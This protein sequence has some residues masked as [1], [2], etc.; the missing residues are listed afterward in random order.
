MAPS[1]DS[2]DGAAPGAGTTTTANAASTNAVSTSD[3]NE[4]QAAF[5]ES[6]MSAAK[7]DVNREATANA[8]TNA[9]TFIRRNIQKFD[10]G[11][12]LGQEY[13]DLHRSWVAGFDTGFTIDLGCF[14]G[15]PLSIELAQKAS[16]YLAVDLSPSAI[17]EL[18]TKLD[19][20]GAPNAT[21]V[22]GDFFAQGIEDNSVDLVYA[23]GVL[24]HFEDPKLIA[25]E[26]ARILRP[27]GAC[28]SL[29]PLATAPENR[30][31][32]AIYR[33]FQS[34]ADW[35]WPFS[36]DTLDVF[37]D[38]LEIDRVR[39]IRGAT[40]VGLAASTV[41]ATGVGTRLGQWGNQLDEKLATSNGLYL[42]TFCWNVLLRM[43]K[44]PV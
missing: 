15:N 4:R 44:R 25:A 21:A 1:P 28:V 18:Q 22:A 19:D 30:L 29:D 13:D 26:I 31:A 40:R 12:Q 17:A 33:P 14:A 9:W 34:D 43:R 32:R 5:Y 24:H 23:R 16:R 39:G 27:G 38:L 2:A 6:R 37:E 11:L 41:G 35:E 42:R 3:L 36:K 7:A 20:S 10:E 8:M